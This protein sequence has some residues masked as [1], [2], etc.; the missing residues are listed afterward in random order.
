M[1]SFN[2][3]WNLA[4]SSRLQLCLMTDTGIGSTIVVYNRNQ[5][6][7]HHSSLSVLCSESVYSPV[8]LQRTCAS[9]F[10][11]DRWWNRWCVLWCEGF[12]TSKIFSILTPES[13]MRSLLMAAQLWAFADSLQ[14]ASILH[15]V[16][17]SWWV[18]TFRLEPAAWVYFIF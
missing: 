18:I 14:M 1:H 7:T 2:L 4:R 16:C 13:Q 8:P 12:S 9:W 11:K 17:P 5:V 3:C 10:L 15:M 6:C